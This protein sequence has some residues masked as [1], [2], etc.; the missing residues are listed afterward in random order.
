MIFTSY[1]K[2]LTQQ[3]LLF[4]NFELRIVQYSLFQKTT[5]FTFDTFLFCL[6]IFKEFSLL[7]KLH[8]LKC[9]SVPASAPTQQPMGAALV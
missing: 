1:F 4:V 9:S 2:L 6:L 7:T 5:I 8:Y 3:Q